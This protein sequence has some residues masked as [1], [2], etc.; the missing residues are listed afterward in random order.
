MNHRPAVHRRAVAAVFFLQG[1]CFASWGSRIP[2]IQQAL[3]LSEPELGGILFAL[4]VGLMVSLP[5]S[6]WAV[7]RLGSRR[8]L[9]AALVAYAL[10]LALVGQAASASTLIAALFFFGLF[11]NAV[12]IAVNT[13]AVAVEA[14]YPRPIM[15]S[16]HGLWSL[17]GFSGA[18][19]GALLTGFGVAPARHFLGVAAFVL[20]GLA[21]CYAFLLHERGTEER[22]HF[23]RPDRQ[24]LGLGL[25][26]FCSMI[27]EG[28]M[29]DWSGVYF[30]KAVGA[31]AGWVGLGYTAFMSTMAGT[32]FCADWLTHKFGFRRLLLTNGV[33][34]CAGLLLAVACPQL[35]PATLGFLLVGAGVSSV[36]PLVY[37][38]AGK[39]TRLAPSAAISAVSSVGFVG[40]LVGPPFIGLVAGAADL[41]ISF[42]LIALCGA[43]IS[44]LAWRLPRPGGTTGQ[45][46][47]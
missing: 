32:R 3:G 8:S 41:R 47:A 33:L 25:I 43:G 42:L 46:Q 12:N 27:C 9:A 44:F 35:V 37:S 10:A 31:E 40:F 13:Q 15:A 19:I 22:P 4:P 16:F 45:D 23:A 17:A 21:G 30:Q 39:S 5:L 34:T 28:A 1:L 38:A 36:V 18:G 2:Q 6:G 14:L 7:A 20:A 24:L 26:A 11:G 29:F